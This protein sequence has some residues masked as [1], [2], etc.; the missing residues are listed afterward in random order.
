MNNADCLLFFNPLDH[1]QTGL[2]YMDRRT[3]IV[4][5]LLKNSTLF[6]YNNNT[7]LKRY[8]F[9]L[10]EIEENSEAIRLRNERVSILP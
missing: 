8:V 2:T 4:K 3:N 1:C 6:I 10:Q 5:R 9:I 7:V